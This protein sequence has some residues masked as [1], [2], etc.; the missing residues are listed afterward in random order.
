MTPVS[1]AARMS[2]LHGSP[3]LRSFLADQGVSPSDLL[4]GR[5]AVI[6]RLCDIG[7]QD[8]APVWRNTASS[9]GR[10]SFRLRGEIVPASM[11]SR[12]ETRFCPLC[13]HEDDAGGTNP[14]SLRR[15][16]LIWSLRVVT[17]CPV[18][19]LPL[20][21]RGREHRENMLHKLIL[22]VPERGGELLALAADTSRREA[23]PLQSYV[24][25]RLDGHRGLNWLDGQTL[26]Q[27]VKA[28]QMLGLVMAF[29]TAV[30]LGSVDRDGWDLAGRAGWEWVAQGV[31]G[32]SAAF[33]ELQA[34]AFERGQGGQ[35]Y[36][37]VF[38][39]LHR[40]LLEPGDRSDHGPI[41][42]VLRD[43]ILQNMD[44]C[45][46]RNLLGEPVERRSKYSVQSLALETGL[47]RQTLC[48][49]LIERDLIAASD[50]DKPYSI[51]LVD[52]E[53][54]REAAAALSHAVPFVKLPTLLNATRP[55]VTCLIDLGL[56]TPL[57]RSV[58]ENTRDKCGFDA[59]EIEQLMDRIHALAPEMTD[60]PPDWV[61]LTQC[62]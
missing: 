47:H 41:K 49:V 15:D 42:Q 59:R 17:T 1:W 2:S 21:Y 29:G 37:T 25:G 11:L 19:H 34:S 36:F 18:H 39:Q 62:T 51:L 24:L 20:I 58:G 10:E 35:N 30:N 27:A 52:A 38:G 5:Q 56:L 53:K 16:R 12:E 45:I 40:W 8:P 13:L 57:H 61:N 46:G 32:L 14:G 9:K 48:K 26:E 6:E 7:G 43:Y 44:V 4:H 60:L 3:S 33:R 23:S 50:A 55:I 22:H 28:T 31:R 54:G